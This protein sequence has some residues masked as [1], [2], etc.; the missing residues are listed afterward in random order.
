MAAT[1]T[2]IWIREMQDFL[3]PQGF[4]EVHVSACGEVVYSKLVAKNIC[5]RVFTSIGQDETCSRPV[6]GD[7]IRVCLVRRSPDGRI[8]GI[9]RGTRVHRT[10]GWR[11]NLQRR[12][13]EMIQLEHEYSS[14]QR[15]FKEA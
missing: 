2:R 5:V 15:Y 8:Y 9:G 4:V 13:D 12:I 6:G 14:G 3:T 10:Q 7:A 11:K 1:Y